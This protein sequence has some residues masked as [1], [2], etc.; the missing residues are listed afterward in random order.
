MKTRRL[1]LLVLPLVIAA[2]C[3]PARERSPPER[4]VDGGAS[5]PAPVAV[6]SPPRTPVRPPTICSIRTWAGTSG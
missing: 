5:T 2:S 3:L 4:P 6:E 1:T